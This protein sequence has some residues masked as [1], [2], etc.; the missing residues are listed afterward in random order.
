MTVLG[1]LHGCPRPAPA[2]P[3]AFSGASA[4][5]GRSA[6]I[7]W[8]AY[9]DG[10]QNHLRDVARQPVGPPR[11]SARLLWRDGAWER[12]IVTARAAAKCKIEMSAS[13][14]LSIRP[15]CRYRFEGPI[16]LQIDPTSGPSSYGLGLSSWS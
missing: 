10:R 15:P 1:S 16:L 8:W 13:S 4:A 2:L 7:V 6:A 12:G 9:F 14:T 5:G 11:S 3:G